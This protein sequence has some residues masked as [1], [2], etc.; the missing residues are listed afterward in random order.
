MPFISVLLGIRKFSPCLPYSLGRVHVISP[1]I[2]YSIFPFLRCGQHKGSD[3]CPNQLYANKFCSI[4]FHL[5]SRVHVPSTQG[6]FASKKI[7]RSRDLY[8]WKQFF[9]IIPKLADYIGTSVDLEFQ[10]PNFLEPVLCKTHKDWFII[11]SHPGSK[12]WARLPNFF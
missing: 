11:S 6:P 2:P 7:L 4:N 9:W 10:P 1:W 5:F 8:L 3:A 12:A